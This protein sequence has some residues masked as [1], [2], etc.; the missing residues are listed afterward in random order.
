MGIVLQWFRR[1]CV[2]EVQNRPALGKSSGTSLSSEA[3]EDTTEDGPCRY[4]RNNFAAH[5]LLL[6][7]KN[8]Y[9]EMCV[10][11]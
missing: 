5:F 11:E 6:L 10:P 9:K 1:T 3:P 8:R 7:L 2:T 4:L